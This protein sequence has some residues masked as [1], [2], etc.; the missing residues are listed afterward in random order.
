MRPAPYAI[1]PPRIHSMH[2][3]PYT[4]SFPAQTTNPS[5]ATFF[6]NSM[7]APSL[8]NGIHSTTHFVGHV[9]SHILPPIGAP[10]SLSLTH[11]GQL[12]RRSHSST[13]GSNSPHSPVGLG[14]EQLGNQLKPCSYQNGL[15]SG[16]ASV[17]SPLS[18]CAPSSPLVAAVPTHPHSTMLAS[19]TMYTTQP[20]EYG[21]NMNITPSGSGTHFSTLPMWNPYPSLPVN[22]LSSSLPKLSYDTPRYKLTPERAIPL[23]KWFEEHKDHPYPS[24]HEKILLCQSTQLTFTQVSTWF[25]NARRRMKKAN[26]EEEERNSDDSSANDP[27]SPSSADSQEECTK[28]AQG[29]L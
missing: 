14:E 13:S 8:S 25:A 24:R 23:I 27:E 6:Q 22:S 19:P 16:G 17:S 1:P 2:R 12:T 10:Q 29:K 9:N 11:G 3:S 7:L 20:Q 5:A 15:S 28:N 18:P 4:P 26:C 21:P